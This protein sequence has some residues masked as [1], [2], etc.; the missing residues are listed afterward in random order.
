M[1]SFRISQIG[2]QSIAIPERFNEESGLWSG[3]TD[4]Y[5]KVGIDSKGEDIANV[6][7]KIILFSSEKSL[8][9]AKLLPE[10]N[11]IES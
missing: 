1:E 11:I 7:K 6:P 8:T 9:L 3:W 4:N 10:L 5:I 2:K